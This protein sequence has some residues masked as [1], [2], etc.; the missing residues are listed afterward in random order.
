MRMMRAAPARPNHYNLLIAMIP[1]SVRGASG[2]ADNLDEL[3]VWPASR[4]ATDRDREEPCP[5][6]FS[7]GRVF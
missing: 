1:N 6:N 7:I 2:L 5:V 3:C 4:R